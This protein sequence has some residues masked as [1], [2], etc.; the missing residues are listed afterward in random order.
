MRD[1]IMQEMKEDYERR[2]RF[3]MTQ[4]QHKNILIIG[5]TRTGKSTIASMLVDPTYVPKD[6][7]L[8]AD[9]KEPQFRSFHLQ[10]QRIVFNVIDTPGLFERG[11]TEVDIRDNEKILETIGKCINMEITKFHVICF[12]VSVSNGINSEDIKSLELLIEYMGEGISNNSCLIITHCESKIDQQRETLKEELLQDLYFK[13]VAPFFQLGIFFS[14]SINPDDYHQANESV[15]HQYATVTEYRDL[16]IEMFLKTD[17]AVAIT[18]IAR[19]EAMFANEIRHRYLP[20]K[21]STRGREKEDTADDSNS[22]STH[23]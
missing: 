5:R 11:N 4:V 20:P 21:G 3:K 15:Y 10:Q 1:K 9:T 17:E 2:G 13:K 7:T 22:N 23:H 18:D 12:C 19:G 8:K 16:L 6:L 14:G